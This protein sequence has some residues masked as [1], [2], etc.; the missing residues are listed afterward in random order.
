VSFLS[1]RG[2]RVKMPVKGNNLLKKDEKMREKI[3]YQS[4][5]FNI[6]RKANF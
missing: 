2:K 3:S 4:K 6:L 5:Y 1:T